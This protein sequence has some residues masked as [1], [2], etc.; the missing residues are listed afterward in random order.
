[1]LVQN[2]EV[3]G[4]I[5]AQRM[6]CS[7]T[8]DTKKASGQPGGR[9]ILQMQLKH[10]SYL[11]LNVLALIYVSQKAVFCFLQTQEHFK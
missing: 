11:L 9:A 10:F 1:M 8:S 7:A 6:F 4:Q 3:K 5:A 2:A